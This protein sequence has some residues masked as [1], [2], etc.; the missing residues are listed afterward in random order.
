MANIEQNKELWG[1][2][3]DWCKDGDEWSDL[4]GGADMQWHASILPR[5][6]QFVPTGNMLE[7]APGFGRWT[8]WLLKLSDHLVVV[9]L[10]EKC[11]EHCKKRFSSEK[12][13][14]YFVN[15]GTSLDMVKENSLDFVFSY[16]SLVHA[17]ADV[18]HEYIC[19]LSGKLSS[20][21]VAFLH[22]SNIGEYKDQAAELVSNGK[23]HGRAFSV[24]A[25]LIRKE[26]ERA[27]LACISQEVFNWGGAL[28]TD[29][30]TVFTKKG[31][32]YEMPYVSLRNCDFMLEAEKIH[33][34]SSL[35][36]EKAFHASSMDVK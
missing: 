20:N 23:D 17:E 11:I 13:V 18:M 8:H 29:C 10:A 2:T 7:I 6:Q 5:I 25:E 27:G 21:G 35:Y 14:D 36:G 16:D 24:T 30:I 12:H 1:E 26:I 31:S 33:A 32:K 9:D 15:D 22:H 19:Q 28:M 4:W 34:L 3:Y